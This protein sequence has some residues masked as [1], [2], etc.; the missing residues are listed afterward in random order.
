MAAA[1][2]DELGA[3]TRMLRRMLDRSMAAEEA[4]MGGGAAAA[5]FGMLEK[6]DE[7]LLEPE[8]EPEIA[9]EF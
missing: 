7:R 9:I 2:D 4:E 6:L 5:I 8:P 1:M 3:A